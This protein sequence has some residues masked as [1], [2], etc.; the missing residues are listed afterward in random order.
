MQAPPKPAGTKKQRPPL[1]EFGNSQEK[2]TTSNEN[3][4]PAVGTTQIAMQILDG[5]SKFATF[6]GTSSSISVNLNATVL[7]LKEYIHSKHGIDPSE[8]DIMFGGA[9]LPDT[10]TLAGS[11]ITEKTT[12]YI[13]NRSSQ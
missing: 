9:A 2:Q 4:F 3:S 5:H 7:Q 1:P 8:Q 6:T 12:I 11:G 10:S 13:L